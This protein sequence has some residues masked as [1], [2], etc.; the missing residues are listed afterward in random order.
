MLRSSARLV[1]LQPHWDP[2][3]PFLTPTF[4]HPL[5]LV[6]PVHTLQEPPHGLWSRSHDSKALREHARSLAPLNAPRDDPAHA[7][8]LDRV[9]TATL[10]FWSFTLLPDTGLGPLSKDAE[11]PCVRTCLGNAQQRMR[12]CPDVSHGAGWGDVLGCAFYLPT[13]SGLLRAGQPPLRLAP[14]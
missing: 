12:R 9:P 4:A 2:P 1:L 14:E 8:N 10:G 6:S 13:G 7:V 3:C 5:P 11:Q